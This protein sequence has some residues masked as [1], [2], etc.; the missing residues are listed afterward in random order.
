MKKV[1]SVFLA[2][3]VALCAFSVTAMADDADA[4]A[5]DEEY[6]AK[7][8]GQNLK[9]YVYNWG[10]YIADGADGSRD[11]IAWFEELTGIDVEYTTFDTNEGLYSKL[12]S[13][14]AYYDVIIPSDYMV[15]RLAQQGMLEK[16][17][18][19]N[20]P[21]FAR[22]VDESFRNPD[23]DEAQEYSVPYTWG[24]VGIIYNTK[25]IESVDSW[26]AL[27]EEEYKGKIL[28]FDNSRDAFAIAL[29]YLGYSLNTEDAEEITEAAELL[30]Q[31]KPL[32][33]AYVMDQI[34]DKMVEE[35]AW[36]APYYAG[37]YL[38]MAEDN[39]ALAF[40]FPKEGT[41]SFVDAMCVPK[42]CVNREAAELFIN[43]MCEPAV[44]AENCGMIGYSTPIS[45]A[46]TMMDEEMTSNEIAYP[47][48]ALLENTEMF[49]NLSDET[50]RQLDILW[51][52]VSVGSL[53]SGFWV[54][55]SVSAVLILTYSVYHMTVK[56]KRAAM[57]AAKDV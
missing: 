27:W 17:N 43:F 7:F 13:G 19:D 44:S 18:F 16:L 9:L 34:F 25:Y 1:L 21:N 5:I 6:Y 2:L 26:S 10:E 41:N 8:K 48:A 32:V 29:K 11:V 23:Y 20:I 12:Q 46:K 33:Q 52:S 36:I 14:S 35:N 39:E 22:Y 54:V 30:K 24:T 4:Y 51:I 42:G 53:T 15:S 55:V 50:N 3:L 40:A 47:S 28:M 37:D 31:Q 49:V 56:K 38:T 57:R 45:A